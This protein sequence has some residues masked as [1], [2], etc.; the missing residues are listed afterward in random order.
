M[1]RLRHVHDLRTQRSHT[2][3]TADPNHFF[4]AVE[5]RMEVAVRA[6]HRHLVTRFQRE[7]VRRSDTRV[8]IH[9]TATVGLERRRGDTHGQHE[10]VAFGRI[11][12]HGVGTY[13][14]FRIDALQR[15]E[16][17]FLPCRQ[18]FV[19]DKALVD[20]LVVIHRKCRYLDLGV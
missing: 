7:D 9:E 3:T 12:G 16:T 8:H 2:G 17:E 19:A 20:I 4:L 14:R 10:H 11:V 13:G 1:Q 6:A 5:V 18:V 15:E